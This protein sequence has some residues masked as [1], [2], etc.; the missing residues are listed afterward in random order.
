MFGLTR[1]F[2]Q[3]DGISMMLGVPE[4][5]RAEQ[6]NMVQ[7]RMLMNSEIPHHLRL[8]LKE[9]DLRITLEYGLS[10]KKMLSHL[11]K[12][13]K[14]SMTSFFGLLLQVAQAI[15]EGRLYMLNAEQ[16]ALHEDYIFVEG[17]LQSGKVYLTYVPLLSPEKVISTGQGFRSLIMTLMASVKELTGDGVQRLLQCCGE[18]DFTPA[19]LKKL[20]AELLSEGEVVKP[21]LAIERESNILSFR[22]LE[23]PEPSRLSDQP[24][25]S[26][27]STGSSDKK[28]GL[29]DSMRAAAEPI[30]A[31]WSGGYSAFQ[32]SQEATGSGFTEEEE[33][34][35]ASSPYRTYIMFGCLL[36]DA[37]LWKFLYMSDPTTLWLA[38]CGILTLL[39]G[40]TCWLV[41]TGKLK[42]GKKEDEDEPDAEEIARGMGL[43]EPDRFF[44][45]DSGRDSIRGLKR[46][47]ERDSMNAGLSAPKPKV[48]PLIIRSEVGN[49]GSVHNQRDPAHEFP[50]SGSLPVSATV[51]LSPD[52]APEKN[53][54]T[55]KHRRAAP[56]LERC[57]HNNSG[58]TERIELD[59]AS[60]IIGRSE[61]VAQYVEKSEGTSRVHAEIF[62]SPTGYVIKDLDSK[63]GTLL[64]GEAMIPYKEYPLMEGTVFTI[65]KGNYIFHTA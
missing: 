13:E 21:N 45:R 31:P 48:E 22:R 55:D 56:Y 38:V 10:R 9:I 65:V 59:R 30:S 20:L 11:L 18:E 63:N 29:Q 57:D 37:L 25:R 58:P 32:R 6:L 14:L 43:R 40:I 46:E 8:Q 28:A 60:F 50:A 26:R 51:L 52:N 64:Q 16:Y 35:Q 7:V 24:L 23:E 49:R 1:D 17:S 54:A 2:M 41:W 47:S 4:G 62:K 34:Q 19:R 36:G 5:L 44:G 61:E 27:S 39:I 3:K 12:G 53:A 15:E 42:L 33:T